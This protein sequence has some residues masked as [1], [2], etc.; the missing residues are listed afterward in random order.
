MLQAAREE[1]AAFL[2]VLT[3]GTAIHLIGIEAW[4]VVDEIG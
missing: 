4:L 3:I 2:A 1:K